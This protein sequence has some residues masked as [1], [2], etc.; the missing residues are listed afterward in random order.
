MPVELDSRSRKIS[1]T[2]T[3][4]AT[5]M[6]ITDWMTVAR[7]SGMPVA[8]CIARPPTPRAAKS[9][10]AH[11]IPIGRLRP[12][13]ATVIAV[14]PIP[15]LPMRKVP[16]MKCVV[17]D[18]WTMPARPD[19]PPEMR[20]TTTITR[21]ALMPDARAAVALLKHWDGNESADSAPAALA[22][23]WLASH[24]VPITAHAVA[25]GELAKALEDS[26]AGAVIDWLARGDARLGSDPAATRR[27]I[28]VA[29]LAE[30]WRD[31]VARLGADPARWRWGDLHLAQWS[32]AILPRVPVGERGQWTVGP[33]GVGGSGSTPMATWDARNAYNVGGG[34]SV[35]MVLD[36]GAWDNSRIINNPG[37]SGDPDSPHYRDLFPLWAAGRYVPFV[38]SDAAVMAAAER[39]IALDP[40]K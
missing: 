19:S 12:S 30:A 23:V 5:K 38:W 14:K 18:T 22:E 9:S 25:T 7:S 15:A 1:F 33:L 27:A 37:A 2:S 13:S 35:R 31:V 16:S 8:A 21:L 11:T 36:V 3:G 39:V 24:L 26:G 29:S 6:T 28:L 34:A 40:A 32:P 17:L 4:V 20:K 10:D